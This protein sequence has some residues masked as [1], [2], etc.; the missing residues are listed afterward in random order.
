MFGNFV[1]FKCLNMRERLRFAEAR[2][3]F[4]CRVRTRTDDHI[5]APQLTD[6]SVGSLA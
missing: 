1:E 2:N 4:H 6:C 3:R 5:C